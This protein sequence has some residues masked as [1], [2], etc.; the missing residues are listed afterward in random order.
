MKKPLDFTG[1][2]LDTRT[3]RSFSKFCWKNI[4][5][6]DFIYVIYLKKLSKTNG[7]GEHNTGEVFA[8][9]S[10]RLGL[11]ECKPSIK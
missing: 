4:N 1:L 7:I 8:R 9:F 10:T 6:G 11:A 2:Y 5:I 3:M